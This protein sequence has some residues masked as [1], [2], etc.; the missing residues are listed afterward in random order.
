MLGEI[1]G[2]TRGKVTGNR[3]L[4]S[5]GHAPK[6]ETSFQ[7]SGKIFGVEVT[8]MGTY[9]SAARA[10]GGLFG[11]GQG[12]TMTKDGEVAAWTGQG[13][14]RFTGSGSAVS[15]RGAVYYQTTSAKLA[16]LN[17]IAVVFEYETDENGNTHGK[18]WEWK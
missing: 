2:E 3:V 10:V 18:F 11:E 13:V 1:I 4:P 15:F 6:V 8:D 12:V 9:R 14:G 7:G 5:E 16:R 17:N